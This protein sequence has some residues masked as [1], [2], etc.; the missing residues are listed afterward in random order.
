MSHSDIWCSVA[1]QEDRG[2]PVLIWTKPEVRWCV[3]IISDRKGVLWC[4][5]VFFLSQHEREMKTVN[6]RI[7]KSG[8][9][10]IQQTLC[11]RQFQW[12]WAGPKVSQ[13]FQFTACHRFSRPSLKRLRTCRWVAACP[14]CWFT[15]AASWKKFN[16]APRLQRLRMA[17]IG[18]FYVG[19]TWLYGVAR[20]HRHTK[21]TR[22]NSTYH[23]FI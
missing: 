12:W 14:T 8:G 20:S 21:K 23:A 10:I 22:Q 11:R 5:M 7:A 13:G 15:N 6:P 4:F 16:A 2:I 9:D 3:E 17:K 18:G 1:V 19:C